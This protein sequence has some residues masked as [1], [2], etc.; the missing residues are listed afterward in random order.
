M[1]LTEFKVYIKKRGFDMGTTMTL[2]KL[3]GGT[4][5]DTIKEYESRN[6]DIAITHFMNED[7]TWVEVEHNLQKVTF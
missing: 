3:T 7:N 5:I 1:I 2:T 6:P 4:V